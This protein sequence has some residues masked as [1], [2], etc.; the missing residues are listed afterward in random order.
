MAKRWKC[1]RCSTEN[2]EGVLTC[3]NC[4]MIRGGVVVP[5][6]FSQPAPDP[7]PGW[8]ATTATLPPSEV[9]P[10]PDASPDESVEPA[11]A[12]P[13]S[14]G[15]SLRNP[16]HWL[17]FA[18]VAVLVGLW[19]LTNDIRSSSGE[20]IKFGALNA[21][22][23]R[24]GDCFDLPD[25]AAEEISDVTVGPCSGAHE[26]EMYFVGPV[27]GSSY[28]SEDQWEPLF[29][30]NC[31]ASFEAYVGAPYDD[32]DLEIYWL[33]PGEEAWFAGDRFIQCSV[34][35]PKINRLTYSLKGSGQ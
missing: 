31:I 20:I 34:Y 30:S 35:D 14:S 12:P 26:Y 7:M 11:T 9:G 21:R 1:A 10:R 22:D 29:D 33:G 32:S 18:L 13:A 8:P 19:V 23:L 3:S 4:R 2:D 15:L 17:I 16:R 27:P 28:P 5:G 6:S 25:P 24:V